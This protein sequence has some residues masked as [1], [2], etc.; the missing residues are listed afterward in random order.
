MSFPFF[1][2]LPTTSN[3]VKYTPKFSEFQIKE[4]PLHLNLRFLVDGETHRDLKVA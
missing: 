3:I 1:F 4:L 2:H